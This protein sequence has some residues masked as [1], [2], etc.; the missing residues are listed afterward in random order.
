MFYIAC[1]VLAACSKE[2][3]D[4]CITSAGKVVEDV[5]QLD[6]YTKIDVNDKFIVE[7]VQDSSRSG[8]AVLVAPKNL[9]GQIRTEVEGGVL[10]VR[11]T[12]TCNFVRSFKIEYKLKLFVDE[13]EEIKVEAAASVF[14]LDTLHIQ[15]LNILHSAL[16]NLDL[17]LDVEGEIYISSFNS[18]KTI[19]RG[20]SK[21]LK[22]SIEEVSSVDARALIAEEVLLDQH[23]PIDCYIN[24]LRII[25][26]KIYNRGNIYYMAEPS[27]LKEL[28]YQ[29]TTGDLILYQ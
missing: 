6:N 19:L 9:L 18:A 8:E 25:Y 14:S 21:I 13:I 10:K 4:D 27:E 5:R 28:N 24:A 3:R 12:N 1:V 23:S 7:L 20:K 29:R 11:N 16:S 26:V 2:Q 22:G 15:K 17:L